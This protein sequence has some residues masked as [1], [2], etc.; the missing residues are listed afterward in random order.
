M[1][2]G[3]SSKLITDELCISFHTVNAHRQK[4]IENTKTRSTG[5]LV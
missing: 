3:H 2:E 1:S 5:G 4:I